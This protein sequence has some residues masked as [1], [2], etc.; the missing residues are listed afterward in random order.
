M[1]NI[2]KTK[3]EENFQNSNS[4][5]KEIMILAIELGDNEKKYLK[6]FNNTFPEKL[7]YEFCL[8]NNL[9]FNSLQELT[10]EIKNALNNNN[11]N[12]YNNLSENNINNLII[13]QNNFQKENNEN[14]INN[15]N[16]NNNINNSFKQNNKK[17]NIKQNTIDALTE[18]LS[19]SKNEKD[20]LNKTKISNNKILLEQN[21]KYK[22]VSNNKNKHYLSHT[23]S[24][25]SKKRFSHSEMSINTNDNLNNKSNYSYNILKKPNNNILNNNKNDFEKEIELSY[26]QSYN[27]SNI[28]NL[29]KN[30][31]KN[32]SNNNL[33]NENKDN[34]R[35]NLNNKN[36]EEDYILNYG[37]RLY[38]KGLKLKEKTNDRIEKLRTRINK[39]N[40]KIYTFKPK[41]NSISYTA[42]TNRYNNKLSYNDE[43]NILNYKEYLDNKIE[44]LKEKYE[45]K[46]EYI[47]TPR[48]NKNSIIMDRNKN[49][50]NNFKSP[51]YEKLYSYYKKKELNLNNLSNKIY[52]KKKLFKPK[53]NNYNSDLINLQFNERQNA[54]KSKSIEKKKKIKDL[55]ENN[56]DEHTGQKFFSP[57][58]NS[59]YE[60]KN[61]NNF[62]VFN[63]LYTDF[64]KTELNKKNLENEIKNKENTIF[65]YLNNNSNEIYE[66]QKIKS[67]EKIFKLLDKDEDGIISKFNINIENLPKNISLIFQPIFEELKQDNETLTQKE[68]LFASSKLFDILNFV[69]KREIINFGMKKRK[70]IE[71]KKYTFMPEINKDYE[72]NYNIIKRDIDNNN[73]Y[74]IENEKNENDNNNN[75][76]NNNEENY[77]VENGN[78]ENNENE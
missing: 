8:Q 21:N 48:I 4:N 47:F 38:H 58:I 2:N 29:K 45:N 43:D 22:N 56:I 61:Q 65:I 74:L 69:Q 57:I 27:N 72:E 28:N 71:E 53:I 67:F 5:N 32:I 17:N 55:I 3:E 36:K 50:N 19:T 49:L 60:R 35:N 13:N 11:N 46:K 25:Q 30:N 64:K 73:N 51:R 16:Q 52:D 1:S 54:Y 63:N 39:K 44:Y 75:N 76:E 10:E 59:N 77:S 18:L 15:Q 33:N 24:S 42:L 66:K 20:N 34:K 6:I 40:K 70:K 31:K 23:T 12:N 7:A 14:I 68:F 62:N 9:D 26:S 37:E 41:I 78:K